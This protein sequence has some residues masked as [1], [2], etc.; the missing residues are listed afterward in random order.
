MIVEIV[1]K[2]ELEGFQFIY[3]VQED[4]GGYEAA[5]FGQ[6]KQAIQKRL[7]CNNSKQP[8]TADNKGKYPYIFMYCN[9]SVK[10]LLSITEL[11]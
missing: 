9:N 8:Q 1:T 5:A 10:Y 11:N 6:I 7:R 2:A 3:Q 4:G